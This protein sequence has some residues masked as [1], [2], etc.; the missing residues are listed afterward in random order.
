MRL[1]VNRTALALVVV[2]FAGLVT[3]FSA[4][5]GSLVVDPDGGAERTG[6]I[7]RDVDVSGSRVALGQGQVANHDV[8]QLEVAEVDLLQVLA[9]VQRHVVVPRGGTGDSGNGV[10]GIGGKRRGS[11]M[12]VQHGAGEGDGVAQRGGANAG[13]R[14]EGGRVDRRGDRGGNVLGTVVRAERHLHGTRVEHVVV[15]VELEHHGAG[16][17]THVEH[18]PVGKLHVVDGLD[19]HVAAVQVE[20]V[21]GGGRDPIFPDGSQGVCTHQLVDFVVAVEHPGELVVTGF[22]HVDGGWIVVHGTGPLLAALVETGNTVRFQIHDYPT[23]AGFR[24]QR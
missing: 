15:I 10:R 1:D 13:T 21:H 17:V 2:V 4:A 11:G 18:L 19:V 8:R 12:E 20:N 22:I 9:G 6:H 7:Q 24:T 5:V 16:T 14:G 3:V 23:Q